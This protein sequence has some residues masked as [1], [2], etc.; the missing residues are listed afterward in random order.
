MAHNKNRWNTSVSSENGYGSATFPDP[1]PKKFKSVFH[2]IRRKL[3]ATATKKLVLLQKER[4]H[5]IL[6]PTILASLV[7]GKMFKYFDGIHKAR[8]IQGKFRSE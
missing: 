1:A 7:N 2:F 3:L 5:R 6:W 8:K 4:Y